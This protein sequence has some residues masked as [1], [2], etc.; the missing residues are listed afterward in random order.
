MRASKMSN[1]QRRLNKLEAL[2]TDSSG[3][4]PYSP[5]WFAYWDEQICLNITGGEGNAGHLAPHDVVAVLR[6][7]VQSPASFHEGTRDRETF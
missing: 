6:Y 2:R 1:L 4:V 7:M 3:L 5:R